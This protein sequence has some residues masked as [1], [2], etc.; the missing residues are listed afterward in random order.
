MMSTI[1][2]S[3]DASVELHDQQ[4][5]RGCLFYVKRGLLAVVILLVALPVLGFT[6]QAIMAPGDAERYPPIG[7]MVDVGGHRL[8]IYCEGEGSPTVILEGGA[9]VAALSWY[10]TQPLIAEHTRVCAYDRAGLGWSELG[11]PPYTPESTARD[12]HTLLGNAGIEPPYVLVGHSVGGKHIRMFTE[13][14]PDEVVGLVFED[15][16][17]ESADPVRTQ[18]EY[19]ADSAAYESGLNFY[20]VLRDLGVVRLFAV[21]LSRSMAPSMNYLPDDVVYRLALFEVEED[22]LQSKIDTHDILSND[23]LSNARPLGDLPLVVLTSTQGLEMQEGWDAAQQNL[24]ALSTNSQWIV[25]DSRHDIH[26]DQPQ[27]VADAVMS[28]IASARSGAPLAQ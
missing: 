3:G 25:V 21:P 9:G 27:Q 8:H 18:A 13:L 2:S 11:T 23:L 12:L 17:H 4:H 22:T 5:K 7:Q 26:I 16:R 14:Y 6:Y 24:V 10:L 20:R 19:E 28:V 15:A 1:T